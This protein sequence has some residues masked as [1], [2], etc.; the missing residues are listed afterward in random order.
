[1][2]DIIIQFA[3]KIWWMWLAFAGLVIGAWIFD[4]DENYDR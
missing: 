3:I 2:T 4:G 1:M